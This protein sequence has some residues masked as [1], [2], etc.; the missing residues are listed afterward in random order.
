MTQ[1]TAHGFKFDFTAQADHMSQSVYDLRDAASHD[2]QDWLRA[3]PFDTVA[4]IWATSALLGHVWT[5]QPDEA[6]ALARLDAQMLRI[7]D[8]HT[9]GWTAPEQVLL[10]LDADVG[11]LRD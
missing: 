6:K 4:A 11:V 5:S 2:A 1:I 7:R 9:K 3:Q 10:C 8:R